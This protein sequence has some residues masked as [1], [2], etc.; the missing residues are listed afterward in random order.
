MK[1]LKYKKKILVLSTN[2][3][4]YGLLK[5][6]ILEL[7]KKKF[8][9]VKF[10]VSG[11]H[12]VENYGNTINEIH[13]DKLKVFKKLKVNYISDTSSSVGQFNLDISKKFNQ[14]LEKNKFDILVVLGDRMETLFCSILALIHNIKIVHLHGGEV[15]KGAIDNE[16]RNAISQISNIHFVSHKEYKK[17]LINLGIDGN[18]IHVVGGLG[19]SA[20]K[21]TKILSKKI[22]EKKFEIKLN[23]K[24][25]LVTYHPVT[26]KKY[27]LKREFFNLMSCLNQFD[28]VIK[29]ITSPNIDA[30]NFEILKIINHFVKNFSNFYF[31]QSLG[32]LNYLSF[33]KHSEGVVGNSSSGILEAPSFKIPT[34]NIGNRQLGRLYSDSVININNEKKNII[35]AL[36]KIINDKKFKIKLKKTKNI[37]YQKETEKKIIKKILKV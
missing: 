19:A 11:S 33:L 2:R 24:F 17:N 35:S 7:K 15:T 27:L 20:I 28:N 9:L 31:F 10:I 26:S 4:D 1:R 32:S 8:F 16:I 37:Y 14:L 36:N 12:C 34:L 22:L 3:S 23:K 18:K 21:K 25:L 6:L 29:I 30:N 5:N 13:K